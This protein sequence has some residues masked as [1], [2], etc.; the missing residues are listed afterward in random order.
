MSD[1]ILDLSKIFLQWNLDRFFENHLLNCEEQ[2]YSFETVF[3]P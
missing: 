2:I 3:T 1:H